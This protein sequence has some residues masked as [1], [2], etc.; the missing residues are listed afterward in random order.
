MTSSSEWIERAAKLAP[1]LAANASAAEEQRRLPSE[2]VDA[3]IRAEFFTITSPRSHGGHQ[4]PPGTLIQVSRELARHC[5]STGWIVA[6]LGIHNAIF[7]LLPAEGQQ[8]IFGPGDPV[9]APGV[10]APQGSLATVEDGFRLSGRWGFGSGCRHANWALLSAV[11]DQMDFET[12]LP[13]VRMAVVSMSEVRVADTWHTS[14]MRGTGSNDLIVADA[15]VPAHR[16]LAFE[17]LLEGVAENPEAACP[18]YTLPL[19]PLLTLVAAAPALGLA[20]CAR[21]AFLSRARSRTHLTGAKQSE[22][23]AALMRLGESELQLSS[24]ESTHRDGLQALTSDRPSPSHRLSAGARQTAAAGYAV[25][26]CALVIDRLV[27]S[28][29]AGAQFESSPLQRCQR[30]IHTLRGHVVFDF[31][32]LS[33]A[34]G[35]ALLGQK[36]TATLL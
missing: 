3:L 14:G 26:Q 10:F 4:E 20:R 21:D 27:E 22:R 8:E 7:G 32:S 18:E 23:S 25:R 6:L 15:F 33:E 24:A 17:S 31:D 30:D 35:Q 9:L 13:E 12:G 28:A 29:G 36:P 16:T 11:T 2:V 1:L 19:M 34:Y 5:G